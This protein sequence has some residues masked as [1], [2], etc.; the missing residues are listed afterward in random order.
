MAPFEATVSCKDANTSLEA[1]C[2]AVVDCFGSKYPAPDSDV[3]RYER[4]LENSTSL[5]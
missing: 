3:R 5:A 2:K 4:L 1:K